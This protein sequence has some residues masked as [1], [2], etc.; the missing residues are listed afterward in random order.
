MEAASST[1]A[2]TLDL[3]HR[4]L[5]LCA[6]KLVAE[7]GDLRQTGRITVL[8]ELIVLLEAVNLFERLQQSFA[9]LN[10]DP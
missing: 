7:L 1:D 6:G 4:Q 5:R 2:A 10:A 9:V 8:Q 3:V